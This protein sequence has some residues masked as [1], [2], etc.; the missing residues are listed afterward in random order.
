[1][2]KKIVLVVALLLIATN[3]WAAKTWDVSATTHNMGTTA[4]AATDGSYVATNE[5]EVCIFCHTPHGGTLNYPL[6]NRTMPDQ[7]G[8]NFFTHY[9]SATLSGALK[10][11]PTTRPVN[12][13]SLL[14]MSCH[15]GVVGVGTLANYSNGTVGL[16]SNEIANIVFMMVAVGSSIG[17]SMQGGLPNRDLRDDHP[18]SF[19]YDL[20]KGDG[21][22][23]DMLFATDIAKG[24]GVRFF[25]AN[26]NVECSS[27]H[28]PHVD[29]NIDPA[30]SP[31]LVTPNT[32][33]ALCLAC[34]NK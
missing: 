26:N 7:S 23:G 19:S 16:P 17:D 27:C 34:H 13:E 18:I 5:D 30:Y 8:A 14:C 33:S 24:K 31:F 2:L 20:A 22:K 21:V 11:L 3:L 28:D 10:G 9:T 15:D 6:W 29:G 1:M 4:T 25:G 32:G 12:A